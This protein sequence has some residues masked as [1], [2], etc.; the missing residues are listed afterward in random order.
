VAQA[1]AFFFFVLA[2]GN[3]GVCCADAEFEV[4]DASAVAKTRNHHH[5]VGD[6]GGASAVPG[7][8]L[9]SA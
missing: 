7:F 4:Q 1:P 3:S 9:G 2:R 6:G 5:R 8:L